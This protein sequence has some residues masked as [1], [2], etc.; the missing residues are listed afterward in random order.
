MAVWQREPSTGSPFHSHWDGAVFTVFV[1]T[2]LSTAREGLPPLHLSGSL[3]LPLLGHAEFACSFHC[4]MLLRRLALQIR[5]GMHL[6][7]PRFVRMKTSQLAW[8]PQLIAYS[9]LLLHAS[10]SLH[11]VL[12]Y[13]R[14]S[15]IIGLGNMRT[16]TWA[17]LAVCHRLGG[18]WH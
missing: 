12:A 4:M 2:I 6:D 15:L 9:H 7:N 3:S 13:K 14:L 8:L 10:Q 5:G 17:T 18:D 1:S 16:L 11:I